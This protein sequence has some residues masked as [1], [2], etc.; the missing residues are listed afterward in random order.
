M[1]SMWNER[2]IGKARDAL[3]AGR[4][5]RAVKMLER[6]HRGC[7]RRLPEDD[8]DRLTTAYWFAVALRESGDVERSAAVLAEA[9]P[10]IE[11]ALGALMPVSRLCLAESELELGQPAA[12]RANASAALAHLERFSQDHKVEG[13][14][15]R[16]L[17]AEAHAAEGDWPAVVELLADHYDEPVGE[18]SPRAR[19]WHDR[20][21]SVLELARQHASER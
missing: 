7:A 5:E 16:A 2:V 10:R 19:Q 21:L 20:A 12:A 4:P 18:V 9:V 17:V 11:D 6:E 8:V 15:A 14:Q 1:R 13:I 3:A